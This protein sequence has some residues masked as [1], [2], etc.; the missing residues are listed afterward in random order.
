MILNFFFFLKNRVWELIKCKTLLILGYK[1]NYRWKIILN[2]ICEMILKK[3][4]KKLNRNNSCVTNFYIWFFLK[5]WKWEVF[6]ILYFLSILY[7]LIKQ[8]FLHLT[9]SKWKN[10]LVYLYYQLLFHFVSDNK[11]VI[12]N[13]QFN[14]YS[15]IM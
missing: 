3:S 6:Y 11:F 2:K 10:H 13:I 8:I 14:K 12:L 5:I 7:F 9:F 15:K 4:L 1:K